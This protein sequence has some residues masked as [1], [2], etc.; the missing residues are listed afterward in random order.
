M[1]ES[2]ASSLASVASVYDQVGGMAFFER[3][4]AAFYERVALDPILRPMYPEDLEA[5]AERL[6]TFL[7]QYF[8][9]P[10]RYEE[11]R[12]DPRLRLRHRPFVI[13]EPARD[14]WLLAMGA[15]LASMQ[16][17]AEIEDE[18]VRYFTSTASFLLNRGGLSIIGD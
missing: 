1:A 15:A 12:G 7:A 2:G 14:A 13:D 4:A 10:R 3:L 11:L 18:L 5:P 17:S 8:G 9:G 6:A 16:V